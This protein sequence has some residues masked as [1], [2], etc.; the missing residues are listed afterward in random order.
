MRRGC[1]RP[2]GAGRG[3][4]RAAR[5]GHHPGHGQPAGAAA[6]GGEL[7]LGDPDQED[8]VPLEALGAVHGEQLDRVGLG[9]RG[10][11]EALAELVLGLEPGQQ[12]RRGVTWPSTAWNSATAWT[13][14]SRLSRRACAA[15]LTDEASST[16]M[17]VVSTIRRTRSRSGSPAAA[18][19]RRSSAASSAKRSR[20]LGGVVARRP[21]RRARRR[22][23]AI[24]VGS[25]PST[26]RLQL[27]LR[28]S[29]NGSRPPAAPPAS[30]RGPA[31]EQRE[32]A[33]ADRPAR[34][35][36]QGEQRRR[37]R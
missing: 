30:S 26:A 36:E 23:T 9:R 24:S 31:A 25:A 20:R 34:P 12:R 37:W 14:R 6:V 35:G 16:S 7:P 8:G 11:V 22:A 5:Y 19:S 15:G 32:V 1:A 10:D 4:R 17:P 29:A 28:R 27:R 2:A 21:G 18:R 13:N 33:R 3:R